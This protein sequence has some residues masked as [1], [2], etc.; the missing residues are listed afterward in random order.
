MRLLI[1]FALTLAAFLAAADV[2]ALNDAP[3]KRLLRATVS[4]DEEEEEEGEGEERGVFQ[5]ISSTVSKIAKPNQTAIKNMDADIAKLTG[6]SIAKATG[7][8]MLQTF[9]AVDP[10][11]FKSVD[12][13]FRSKAF[14]TFESYIFRI[15][16]QDITKQTDVVR[17]FRVGFGD[18][19]ALK[20][21]IKAGESSDE[22]V[23]ASGK[24]FQDQ[25]LNQLTTEGRLW[26]EIKWIFPRKYKAYFEDEYFKLL[27]K[28]SRELEKQRFAQIKKE[29]AA[30]KAAA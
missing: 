22:T 12:D 15:N 6:T 9:K 8:S 27:I 29:L 18:K 23:R 13:L 25:L 24:Y 14:H 26:S 7:T 3:S 30:A 19:K 1:V 21:F 2:S 10:K 16:Q 5:K 28:Q 20:L 17:I 4:V 11:N